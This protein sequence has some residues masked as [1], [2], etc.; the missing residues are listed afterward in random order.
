MV[1][2]A[3]MKGAKVE[4]DFRIVQN[5]LLSMAATG[6]RG[7]PDSEKVKIRDAVRREV[8]PLFDAGKLRPVTDRVMPLDKA[9]AAHDLMRESS[10]IGKILLTPSR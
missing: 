9:Q 8:W 4:V 3:Y 5:R 7:R 6:L 1:N 10:H 2:I